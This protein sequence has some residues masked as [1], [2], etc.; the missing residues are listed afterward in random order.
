MRELPE[1]PSID[2][3]RGEAKALVRAHRARDE[4]ARARAAAVLGER[5]RFQLADAQFVL[6]REH[7]FRSWRDFRSAI[8]SSPLAA[9]AALE[10][11]E[12]VVDSG[13]RYGDGEPV[14]VLVRK[15]LHRYTLSDRGRAIAKSGK[16]RGW[17]EAAE[18]AVEP[19]NIDRQGVVFVP[20]VAGR[21]LDELARRLA[22]ASRAVHEAVLGLE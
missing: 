1:R 7:G 17:R 12:V 15:R 4:A 13:L 10:R 8:E 9:L 11:G 21:D 3:Y 19:M 6:A 18:W 14:E 5:T 16:P 22:D 20:V 2:H